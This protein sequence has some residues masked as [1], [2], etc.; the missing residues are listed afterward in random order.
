MNLLLTG[1]GVFIALAIVVVLAYHYLKTHT[2]NA[3]DAAALKAVDAF[4]TK[5]EAAAK[6]E[7]AKL[8]G[9]ITSGVQSLENRAASSTAGAAASAPATVAATPAP[10]PADSAAAASVAASQAVQAAA[11][12]AAAQAA[13]SIATHAASVTTTS[14]PDTSAK[15]VVVGSADAPYGSLAAL[16]ATGGAMPPGAPDTLSPMMAS[17]LGSTPAAIAALEA[18]AAAEAADRIANPDKYRQL[19][20][21]AKQADMDYWCSAQGAHAYARFWAAGALGVNPKY[22]T[23]YGD[24]DNPPTLGATGVIK[25][26]GYQLAGAEGIQQGE[27]HVHISDAATGAVLATDFGSQS[28]RLEKDTLCTLTAVLVVA[29]TGVQMR[30]ARDAALVA[31]G[32]A[33]EGVA[34][35]SID[36]Y[37]RP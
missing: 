4:K 9:D 3:T 32:K 10:P 11:A 28:F 18:R 22:P 26:G 23:V 6:V 33:A 21:W 16:I 14:A 15:P 29:N 19:D 31:S 7:V 24:P 2:S 37:N 25:A 17:M 12:S 35:A 13:S 5:L 36:L 20:V 8:R 30:A 34:Y 1:V 27:I